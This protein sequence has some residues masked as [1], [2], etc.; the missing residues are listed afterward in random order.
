[1]LFGLYRSPASSVIDFL[2][3][4]D[5]L[6]N[7]YVTKNV[8]IILAGDLNINLADNDMS[9][10]LKSIFDSY[11]IVDTIYEPTRVTVSTATTIDHIA[12]NMKE[13]I[14]AAGIIES[15][16]SDHSAQY[17]E[18]SNTYGK[19]KQN[20]TKTFRQLKER[21][22]ENLI[23]LL[24]QES[25]ED[26]KNSVNIDDKWDVFYKV[27]KMH[28]DMAC[29]VLTKKVR[30]GYTKVNIPSYIIELRKK[31]KDCYVL[32]KSTSSDFFKKR[33]SRYRREYL[34][35]LKINKRKY[36]RH[37]IQTSKN[38]SKTLWEIVT[39]NKNSKTEV[40]N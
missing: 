2:S 31:A 13:K 33:Y 18:L 40:E 8:N 23:R 9:S 34:N 24:K 26:V 1:M 39:R 19:S 12:T 14:I 38:A 3:C 25:W 5:R 7:D 16:I 17:L 20:I 6:L 21:N 28:Y 15:C 22:L 35:E 29:P 4:L 30:N 32:Y 27:F 37:I 36:Y 11:N 10:K